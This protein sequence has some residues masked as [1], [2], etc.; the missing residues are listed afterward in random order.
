MEAM[1]CSETSANLYS[2]TRQHFE[3]KGAFHQGE[4][5][6]RNGGTSVP[7]LFGGFHDD[8][9]RCEANGAADEVWLRLAEPHLMLINFR[10]NCVSISIVL[11]NC[12]QG[13]AK[14]LSDFLLNHFTFLI[15]STSEFVEL[16]GGREAWRG[17]NWA[18][19]QLVSEQTGYSLSETSCVLRH[20]WRRWWSSYA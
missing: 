7:R 6:A 15:S 18:R 13:C 16:G 20:T 11:A 12:L 1:L 9:L 8:L 2:D 10:N 4:A 17:G 14:F 3:E 5:L 19:E